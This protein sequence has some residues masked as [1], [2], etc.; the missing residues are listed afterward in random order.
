VRHVATQRRRVDTIERDRAEEGDGLALDGVAVRG[1]PAVAVEP[2][3]RIGPE[4]PRGGRLGLSVL[5]VAPKPL[6]LGQRPEALRPL[7]TVMAEADL[8]PRALLEDLWMPRNGY[9]APLLLPIV[10]TPT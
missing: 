6:C 1:A 8:V 5:D 10:I 4:R 3:D 7:G 2:L 9:C